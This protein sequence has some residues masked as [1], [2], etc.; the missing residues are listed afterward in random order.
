MTELWTPQVLK[1]NDIL[2]GRMRLVGGC[3]RDFL[4][5]MTPRDWD[6]ATPVEPTEVSALLK[7]AGIRVMPT[8]L[9]HGVIT[10]FMDGQGYEIATLR[11]DMATDGSGATVRYTDDYET[12]ARRRDFTINA[13]SMDKAGRLYDYFGGKAD[14]KNGV[15][16]FIGDPADRIPED[17]I[18]I[19]RYFR[20]WSVFG[21]SAP[22]DRIIALCHRYRRG[23]SKVSKERR[24]KEFLK[25]LMS[26][27]VIPALE[28]MARVDV[29][30]YVLSSPDI[31]TLKIFLKIC[32][33][34]G[35]W[36]RLSII[37]KGMDLSHLNL[38]AAQKELL[39]QLAEP[40]SFRDEQ[41]LKLIKGYRGERVF[42]FLLC[43][44]LAEG[45]ISREEY[46]S[47]L[48]IQVPEMPVKMSDIERMPGMKKTKKRV[49][50]MQVLCRLWV[51]LDFPADKNFLMQQ[52]TAYLK[53]I[54]RM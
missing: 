40:V 9:K 18:R 31:E 46:E 34:A 13:M 47:C 53:S 12:D 38:E 8:S 51:D 50:A 42:R 30:K 1:I 22:D 33:E 25:I 29:L 37:S 17:F 52:F 19:Y 45:E 28:E 4:Q 15:V 23:L 20:F 21:G 16:R 41:A 11:E 36:E 7:S 6:I 35:V 27:R 24:K 54:G 2:G 39:T 10:A 48:R 5:G 49:D 44:G 14:L 43:R 26:P 32:P 3:V